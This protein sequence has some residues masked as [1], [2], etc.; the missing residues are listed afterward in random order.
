MPDTS[1]LKVDVADISE[2]AEVED[3]SLEEDSFVAVVVTEVVASVVVAVVVA[4]VVSVVDSD[5]AEVSVSEDTAVV[6]LVSAVVVASNTLVIS[7]DSVSVGFA[8]Q[9]MSDNEKPAQS[10]SAVNFSNLCISLIPPKVSYI[11]PERIKFY[12]YSPNQSN[13]KLSLFFDV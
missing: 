2:E 6:S 13:C 9:E 10:R 8:V 5:V 12:H 1:S 11:I 4:S 3:V 7:E